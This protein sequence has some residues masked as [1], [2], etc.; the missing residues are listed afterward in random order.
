MSNFEPLVALPPSADPMGLW[1]VVGSGADVLV[2]GEGAPPRAER[3]PV[4]TTEPPIFMGVLEG[5]RTWAIGI[6]E[7]SD[8]PDGYELKPLR[9]L[10]AQLDTPSW[11]LAGRAVQLVEWA[12]TSRFCGRCGATTELA[13][14]QPLSSRSN[15]AMRFFWAR[16]VDS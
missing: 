14:R 3:S 1:Y 8:A 16:V 9:A 15:A 13:T 11:M 5:V 2:D 12:R 4:E 7:L 10:G 6:S